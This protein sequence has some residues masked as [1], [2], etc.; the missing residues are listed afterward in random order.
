[1]RSG[2]EE[3]VRSGTEEVVAGRRPVADGD[4]PLEW[5]ARADQSAYGRP[6]NRGDMN[7][8][9]K[10]F[11]GAGSSPSSSFDDKLKTFQPVPLYHS[12]LRSAYYLTLYLC[13]YKDDITAGYWG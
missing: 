4:A 13:G 1:M 9:E 2:T 8:E 10:L 3:V 5:G 11:L 6:T 7:T 12:V